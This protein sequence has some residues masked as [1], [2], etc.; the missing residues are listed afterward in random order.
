MI[1]PV[2]DEQAGLNWVKNKNV[3]IKPFANGIRMRV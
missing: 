1:F 2:C 3:S